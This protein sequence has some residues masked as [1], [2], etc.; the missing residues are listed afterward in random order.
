MN[1]KVVV[2]TLF[3]IFLA[4]VL[5]LTFS[6]L[7]SNQK[8]G[9][10]I[11]EQRI[12]MPY[13]QDAN[14]EWMLIFF[15]YVGCTDVCTPL[16]HHLSDFYDSPSFK[17]LK[18]R[19][20]VCFINLMPNV[21][22]DQPDAFAKA[23]NGKFEGVYLTQKELMSIDRELSVFFSRSLRDKT[24][25]NHSDYLYLVQRR[26]EGSLILKNIYSTHPLNQKMIIED[27]RALQKGE[28]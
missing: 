24:T 27:I 19:V 20:G 5:P 13:L 23:F 25:M 18:K 4:I 6:F 16:L 2:I 9:R 28:E 3:F 26:K 8:S 22:K 1:R 14:K 12:D 11:V 15:G 17:P 21:Q 7:F 10:I